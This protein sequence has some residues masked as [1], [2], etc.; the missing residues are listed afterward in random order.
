[1]NNYKK[2]DFEI[3]FAVDDKNGISKII[4]YEYL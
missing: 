3:G 4:G 2:G 1:M